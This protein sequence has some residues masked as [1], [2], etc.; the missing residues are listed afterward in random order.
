MLSGM[1]PRPVKPAAASVMCEIAKFEIRRAFDR[2][3]E[4]GRARL[5]RRPPVARNTA[6]TW[7]RPPF[8]PPDGLMV[9]RGTPVVEIDG[10]SR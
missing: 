7:A 4:P 5:I 6:G 9:F 2:D 1:E 3:G 10:R 8:S